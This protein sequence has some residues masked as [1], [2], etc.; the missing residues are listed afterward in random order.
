[1]DVTLIFERGRPGRQGS[2][3]PAL[4]VPAASAVQD[5]LKRDE[6]PPLPEVSELDMIRHFVNLSRKNLAIDTCFYPL[7]SCTMKYNPK[8]H[9]RVAAMDGFAQLHPLLPQLRRGGAL[10]QGALAVIYELEN[11]LCDILGFSNFTMQPL[12]GAH[13]ELTGIM[14]IAAYHKKHGT[15]RNTILIPDAAHGTNPATAAIAGFN[16][17]ELPTDDD[18]NV[19]MAA[20]DEAIDE[21]TAGIMLTCPSTLGL[22]DPKVR[23]I[24]RKVHEAGGLCYCDGANLNAIVGR[25]RP[26]DLGFDVMHVNLHKTFSTPHGGGGPGSGVVGVSHALVPFLPSSRVI[27]RADGTYYLDYHFEDSIGYIAPFYG[28]FGMLL[29]AYAYILTLGRDGLQRVS[30]NAVLNANYLL[31]KLKHH[32]RVIYDRKCMHECVLS[33]SNFKEKGVNALDLAKALLDEGVHPPTVYFPLIVPEAM[34]IEP[35]ETESRETL[36]AF[37]EAFERII[38]RVETEPDTFAE[39]PTQYPVT[40]LDETRAARQPDLA[41]LV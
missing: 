20:L 4:D 36:D 19:D 30:E 3:L 34:M 26:G 22:Y 24:C 7:G 13:G 40:R 16:V 9:E 38:S 5:D 21:D 27:K 14:M 17:K 37:V 8:F 41:S 28:N 39:C 31:A 29:R 11:L 1:M 15:Q 6:P 10:T 23:E 2:S 33:A 12:A 25:V 35:T 18:G 32:F